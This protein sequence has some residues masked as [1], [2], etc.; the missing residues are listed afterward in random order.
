MSKA[1]Q[2]NSIGQFSMATSSTQKLLGTRDREQGVASSVGH[3]TA[4]V[5]SVMEAGLCSGSAVE[6]CLPCHQTDVGSMQE[7][8]K[9]LMDIYSIVGVS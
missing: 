8:M 9:E 2:S 5:S 6:N 1:L 3:M 4:L 7:L